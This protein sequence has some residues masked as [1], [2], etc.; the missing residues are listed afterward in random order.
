VLSDYAPPRVLCHCGTQYRP[1]MASAECPHKSLITLLHPPEYYD[2]CVACGS[3][4]HRTPECR[5]NNGAMGSERKR[6][7]PSADP[8]VDIEKA[9]ICSNCGQHES[10]H[11]FDEHCP[12]VACAF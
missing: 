8:F 3:R 11:D 1:D 9:V 12:E 5:I 2:P 10:L 7:R 6:Y 4:M